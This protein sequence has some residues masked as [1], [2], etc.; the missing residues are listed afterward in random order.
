MDVLSAAG[1][2]PRGVWMSGEQPGW[3]CLC[4][5]PATSAGTQQLDIKHTN[6]VM[7]TAMKS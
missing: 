2:D 6:V 4:H 3:G 5:W 1:E 7:R